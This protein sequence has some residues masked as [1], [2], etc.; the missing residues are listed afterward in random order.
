MPK[1]WIADVQEYESH[2]DSEDD[3]EY[4]EIDDVMAVRRIEVDELEINDNERN[5][6]FNAKNKNKVMM[7]K[8]ESIDCK[9]L[10]GL[11]YYG[12]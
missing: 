7:K 4:E 1:D 6:L 2:E 5:I 10:Q 8:V 11:P 9:N 3:S 12:N